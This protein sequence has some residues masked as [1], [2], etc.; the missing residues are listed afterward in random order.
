MDEETLRSYE[1]GI[2]QNGTLSGDDVRSLIAALRVAQ[3][4]NEDAL[5]HY[6]IGEECRTGRVYVDWNYVAARMAL[7]LVGADPA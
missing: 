4:R 3:E 1:D 6:R 7:A 5:I 2:D